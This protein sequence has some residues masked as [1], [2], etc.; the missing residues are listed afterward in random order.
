M[1]TVARNVK[2][3]EFEETG[4]AVSYPVFFHSPEHKQIDPAEWQCRKGREG[5]NNPELS[6]CFQLS[7]VAVSDYR[8]YKHKS[9]RGHD[10]HYAVRGNEDRFDPADDCKNDLHDGNVR[11]L[12]ANGAVNR[13]RRNIDEGGN[14]PSHRLR[15]NDMST[16]PAHGHTVPTGQVKPC[17]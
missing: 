3:K 13:G 2:S 6:L 10:A 16:A 5:R 4:R 1:L 7:W 14:R 8:H 17:F 9:R 15:E 12:R 11:S